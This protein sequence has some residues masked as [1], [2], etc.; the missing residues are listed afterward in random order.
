MRIVIALGG[1]ALGQTPEEQK[2]NAII[3][4]KKILPIIK[5]GH[6]VI[7]THGNG[8]QVGLINLA[9]DE[10]KK[11][12]PK[13]YN[14]PF[15]ECGAMSQGYIAYHLNNSLTNELIKN[16]LKN[17]IVSLITS[18][19]VDKNDPAFQN[20]TKPIGSFYS[21]EDALKLPYPVKEDSG[22][23]YR[24]VVPS[25]KPIR[26]VEEDSIK[27]LLKEGFCVICCG[28]GGIPVINEN[29]EYHGIDAVIDKD[30]ASSK[31]ASNIDSDILLILTA[32]ENAKINFN[33]KD[34]KS[35][36]NIDV[37]TLEKYLANDEFKTGSM[38]PKVEACLAFVKEK[39]NRIAIIT[40]IEHAYE[41]I[42]LKKG[43]IIR[44][45]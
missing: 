3:T 29:G 1:N 42:N 28:G 25:P 35:L 23:G 11:I 33:T 8:P 2:K 45:N 7:I 27:N 34:E 36:T 6:E 20:P 14:M 4:S 38:K 19:E 13:V 22:R 44:N 37:N 16:N 10:G 41:A 15:S 40:D 18:V 21:K 12:N 9:F 26:I 30:F 39:K 43:T 5:D 32:V 24:R 31:L 17:N